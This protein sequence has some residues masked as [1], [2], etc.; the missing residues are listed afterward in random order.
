MTQENNRRFKSVTVDLGYVIMLNGDIIT[1][2]GKLREVDGMQL[3]MAQDIAGHPLEF[4][5]RAPRP[6]EID[7]LRAQGIIL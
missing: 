2:D 7:D 5:F 4:T 6:D 1:S 3:R